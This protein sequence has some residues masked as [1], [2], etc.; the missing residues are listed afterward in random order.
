VG[1]N[2]IGLALAASTRCV[3]RLNFLKNCLSTANPEFKV[4]GARTAAL[5]GHYWQ[6]G[7][8]RVGSAC[9]GMLLAMAPAPLTCVL[10]APPL[11][12]QTYPA[13]ESSLIDEYAVKL[14]L[15][16]QEFSTKHMAIYLGPDKLQPFKDPRLLEYCESCTVSACCCLRCRHWR[17]ALRWV[18]QHTCMAHFG[19]QH[20]TPH[21]LPRCRD[22]HRAAR[23][24]VF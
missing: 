20:T 22:L 11:G 7:M 8:L 17:C 6:I 13:C 23:G 1:A 18:V 15:N 24:H 12:S 9:P 2:D 4:R 14:L 5:C 10:R 21:L 19:P 16:T 3:L